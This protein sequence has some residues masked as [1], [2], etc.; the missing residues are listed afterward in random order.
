MK[1]GYAQLKIGMTKAEVVSIL[2]EPNSQR[3]RNGIET[4]GW[5]NSEFK[6]ILRGGRLERRITV[7]FEDG[8]VIGF[9]GENVNASAW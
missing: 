5:F 4:Y 7:E 8:K 1:N 3:V 6:G 2:G 9:D